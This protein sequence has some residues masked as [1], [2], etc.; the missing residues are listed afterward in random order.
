ML[1]EI[2]RDAAELQRVLARVERTPPSTLKMMLA[3]DS[4][5]VTTL[6]RMREAARRTHVIG[7]NR[8]LRL[9]Q[10]GM[11]GIEISKDVT[12]GAGVYFAYPTG[13]V[14]AGDSRIGDRVR[15]MGSN[16]VGTTD[17]DDG[18]PIVEDDVVLNAGAR[19]LGPVRV[20]ARSIIA[21][22]AVVVTDLP[23]DSFAR[24]DPACPTT[25]AR[26]VAA[27]VRVEA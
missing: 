12:L 27:P 21:A 14:V 10:L 17:L 13:T 20:G 16:T 1:G 5:A 7:V 4:F 19:I 15:F 2:R 8:L 24:G 18:Y 6:T 9:V 11:Y 26:A 3:Y 25:R 23:A 22:N